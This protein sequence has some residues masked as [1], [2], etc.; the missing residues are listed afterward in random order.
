MAPRDKAKKF[1][2][3]K[4]EEKAR[5]MAW[6]EEGI[7]S[8]A[9]AQWLGQHRSSINRLINR[10]RELKDGQ[11]PE[12]MGGS[13]RPR[14]LSKVVLAIIQRQI[15]K[16]PMMTAV[17][18][19]SS[20]PELEEI[21][22]R[23]I[24]RAILK[25]LKMPSRS[26]AQKPLLTAGMKKKRLAFAQKYKDW[27]NEQWSRVMFSDE[28]TF[29]CIRAT[30]TKVRRPMGSDR[31]DSRYTVKT[32][33]HPASLMVWGSFSG[34]VGHGGLFFLSKNTTIN[35][36]RYQQTLE[37]HLLP[38]MQIHQCTHFLQDGAP[39]H[40]SKKTKAFLAQQ[41]F[42]VMVGAAAFHRDGLAGQ[43]PR[44][45]PY[46]EP[47]EHYEEWA[48]EQGHRLCPQAAGRAQEAVG[49]PGS[50]HVAHLSDSMPRRLQ[51][52]LNAKGEMAKY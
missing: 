22:E 16:Y 28:S 35:S 9:I 11:L 7:S 38:F 20:L 32:V 21:L 41:P 42:I 33:K 14:N 29:R 4:I 5:I 27:T 12:R 25:D 23:S 8:E 34:A 40:A 17:D 18:L 52:V 19:K 31:Y 36:E 10:A 48:E 46:R 50:S 3:L 43:Q 47:V 44:S 45:Q 26:A 1:T 2:P 49:H 15:V 30:K 39:C 51:M 13:G 24:R 6:K 37:D